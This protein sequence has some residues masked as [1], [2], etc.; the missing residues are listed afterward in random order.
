MEMAMSTI[1]GLGAGVG[2]RQVLDNGVNLSPWPEQNDIIFR[3]AFGISP[4]DAIS[5]NFSSN[6]Q[7]IGI[8]MCNGCIKP[9]SAMV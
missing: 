7:R 3:V 2:P 1:L 5:A 9:G 4:I 6:S 8:G